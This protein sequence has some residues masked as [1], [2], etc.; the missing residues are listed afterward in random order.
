MPQPHELTIAQAARLIRE[1]QLSPSDLMESL[2]GRI[3]RLEPR[4]KAWV[5]LDR[6]AAL[7]EAEQ[8]AGDVLAGSSV[9][10]LHGVPVGV[11]DIYY[12]AGIPTTACSKVY[13]DFVPDFD[14][15]TVERLNEAGAIILGKTVTTEFACLD[16]SPTLNPWNPAHTPGGSSSGSAAAVAARMCPAALGSQ[17][18][19]SVLR[20]ASYNGVVGLKP[21]YGRVSRHGVIPVSWSLDTV[22]W[23]TRTVEDAALLLE[24]M[25]G[26]DSQDPVA[27]RRRTHDYLAALESPQAPRIGW[28]QGFFHEN[29]DPET[30]RHMSLVVE[31]LSNAGAAIEELPSPEGIEESV[32]DQRTIMAVEAAAFHEPMYR[33][34][35]QDYQPKLRELL[36]R[37]LETD[38]LTYSR[39]LER[40]TQFIAN[41]QSL[42]ERADVLLTPT[43]PTP[44][45]ADLTNTGN[46]LFQ[47]PWTHCGLPAITIPSG[48]ASS[49][50]PL[51]IQLIAARFRETR[52]LAAARWCEAVLDLHLS[53]PLAG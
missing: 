31:R 1:G 52:L 47:G 45:L 29:A 33:R 27:S 12:T 53:P 8:R 20:P 46:P 18:V 34:Q 7:A 51:G 36:R 30:R 32:E 14:A 26:H 37:G 17:T 48:L 9:G 38:V 49:G 6:E 4:L 2:L 25:A 16:P 3:D 44:A 40:R 41:A 11:K 28:L 42:S 21:T 35:A 50:L 15:A 39:A 5:Y 13:A 10:P 24:V 19:G 43:T 23:M 22:G